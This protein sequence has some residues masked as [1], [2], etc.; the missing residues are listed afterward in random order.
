MVRAASAPSCLARTP[1]LYP[2]C[3]RF[4]VSGLSPGRHRK[5]VDE[6]AAQQQRTK[7]TVK[8]HIEVPPSNKSEAGPSVLKPQNSETRGLSISNSEIVSFGNVDYNQSKI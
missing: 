7:V 8:V 1:T 5:T 4:S 3:E 2:E 6:I